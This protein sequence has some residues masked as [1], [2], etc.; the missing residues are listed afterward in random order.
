MRSVHR[1]RLDQQNRKFGRTV[2][3]RKG[4]KLKRRMPTSRP[5][6]LVFPLH[7]HK[8]V[9]YHLS[10]VVSTQHRL[11]IASL[12]CAPTSGPAWLPSSIASQHCPP[13]LPRHSPPSAPPPRSEFPI[14]TSR[15]FHSLSSAH[16]HPSSAETALCDLPHGRSDQRCSVSFMPPSFPTFRGEREWDGELGKTNDTAYQRSRIN[17]SFFFFQWRNGFVGDRTS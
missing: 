11:P 17:P 14:R 5:N 10:Q 16:T 12:L 9:P 13:E 6:V 2:R 15:S 3:S 7:H 4:V 1:L 8:P